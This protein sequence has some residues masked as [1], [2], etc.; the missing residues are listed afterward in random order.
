V[1]QEALTN[2]VRHA[3]PS[4]IDI[5]LSV[6]AAHLH[7]EVTDDGIGL[8]PAHSRNGFGLRGLEERVRQLDGTMTISRPSR[9]GTILAIRIRVPYER[10]EKALLAR[11]AG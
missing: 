4:T 11:A 1:V 6:R 7:V 10:P 2:A 9:G 5:A 8:N 3:Q